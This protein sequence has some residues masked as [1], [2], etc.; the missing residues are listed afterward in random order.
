[1]FGTLHLASQDKEAMFIERPHGSSN[2]EK[3]SACNRC[4]AKKVK[5]NPTE[6]GCT[7]CKRLGRK[8]T[9]NPAKHIGANRRIRRGGVNMTQHE[10]LLDLFAHTTADSSRNLQ[11]TAHGG[12][13]SPPRGNCTIDGSIFGEQCRSD[14]LAEFDPS[15]M[16]DLCQ[17]PVSQDGDDLSRA[18]MSTLLPN[19][20]L[21]QT[22]GLSPPFSFQDELSHLHLPPVDRFQA[23]NATALLPCTPPSP[24]F[25]QS[26][27]CLAAVL[28]AV[29]ELETSCNPGH[30][31]EL[32]SIIAYQKEAI[33]RCRLMLKCSACPLKRENLVLLA[34]MAEKLVSASSQIVLIYRNRDS[35]AGTGQ[36][37][38]IKVCASPSI[39]PFHH[40]TFDELLNNFNTYP[41]TTHTG[42]DPDREY[43]PPGWREMLLGD[44]EISS[45][46]EWQQIMRVL[47]VLQIKGVVELLGDL[48]NVCA[49]ALG[50]SRMASLARSERILAELRRELSTP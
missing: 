41:L 30:R 6:D 21:Y 23:L 47:I 7:R 18:F 42:A 20:A 25:T 36:S 9:S 24:P 8:C 43:M 22:P 26:C 39:P 2:L 3:N 17:E 28:F 1:M 14:I 29:E 16:P 27:Q 11:T 4:R 46:A 38:H 19:A 35:I 49:E 10:H 13:G 50:E 40:D 44:Y 32:D 37:D 31:S 45:V 15:F 48:R 12:I 5:C 33:K 34:F